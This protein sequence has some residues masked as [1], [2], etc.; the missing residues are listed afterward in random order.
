MTSLYDALEVCLQALG[1]G[2]DMESTLAMYPDLAEEL[3]PILAASLKARTLGSSSLAKE[4]QDRGRNR[5]LRRAAELRKSKPNQKRRIL[6]LF[7]RLAVTLGLAVLFLLSSTGLVSAST[8][9]LPGDQLYPLKRTWEQMRLFFSFR[10]QDRDLLESQY[11]QERLDETQGVLARDRSVMVTFSGLVTKQNGNNWVVS[12][13]PILITKTT[14]LNAASILSGSP[15][16][17]IGITRPGGIVEA[18]EIQLLGSGA[19]LPPLEPSDNN[20]TELKSGTAVPTPILPTISPQSPGNGSQ[21]FE[22][23]G[24]VNSILGSTWVINSQSV[25]VTGAQIQGTILPGAVIL[26][27]G[28]YTPDGRFI[29]TKIEIQSNGN[30]NGP[31]SETATPPPEDGSGRE[32]DG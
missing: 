10:I 16:N 23:H 24:V 18:Q 6:S 5:V 26:F 31:P 9:S 25:I 32:G 2:K 27:Q 22:F 29:A 8:G 4:A 13:I 15:V 1:E 30:N 19:S 12:G 14:H 3:K 20:E 7:P 11:D 21:I 17:I 28:Y